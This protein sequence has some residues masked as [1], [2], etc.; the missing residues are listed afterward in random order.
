[1][2]RERDV[3]ARGVRAR[4]VEVLLPS[5]AL[6]ENQLAILL[7]AEASGIVLRTILIQ[8]ACLLELQRVNLDRVHFGFPCLGRSLPPPSLVLYQR[9][10][11]QRGA[12]LTN[13]HF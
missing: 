1:M 10:L 7:R 13:K 6:T 12:R 2:A 9:N 4:G 3:R 11:Q 8:M 5:G